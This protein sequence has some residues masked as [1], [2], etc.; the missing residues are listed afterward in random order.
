[1]ATQYTA[2]QIEAMVYQT[3]MQPET[4][5][6]NRVQVWHALNAQAQLMFL[7]AQNTDVA[8]GVATLTLTVRAGVSDYP[9][10][11][12]NFGKDICIYTKDAANRYHQAREVKRVNLQDMNL[13]YEG[14]ATSTF[15][16]H[17]EACVAMYRDETG[18]VYAR[19]WPTPN[20]TAQYEV[21]YETKDG[22][23]GGMADSFRFAPFVHLLR[24]RV[25]LELLPYCEWANLDEKRT[26]NRMQTLAISLQQ[27]EQ[28]YAKEYESYIDSDHQQ[29]SYYR[30]GY[31]EECI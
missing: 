1:M 13:Q 8:W 10:P 30:L 16:G 5:T 3:L 4:D 31:A 23:F 27:Q 22:M 26:M 12:E 28:R 6:P 18:E 7:A 29:G 15:S 2:S 17:S 11:D 24:Y 21:T 25:A 19:F 20:A 14:A 9:L